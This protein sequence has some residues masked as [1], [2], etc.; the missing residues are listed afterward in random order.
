MTLY[1]GSCFCGAVAF[2]A[3]GDLA[4]GTMRCNCRFCRKM[5]YWEMLLP[6][7]DGFR[8]IRGAEALAETPLARADRVGMHHRFCGR[9]GTRLWTEGVLAE[10][11]G[12]F[13]QVCVSALDDVPLADL[14]AAPIHHADGAADNWW[15]EA[16]ESRHL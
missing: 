14:V 1:R 11:G 16:P 10:L 7:P 9:C 4:R 15:A 2:E 3:E 6:D 13:V 12:R 8:L 5:R